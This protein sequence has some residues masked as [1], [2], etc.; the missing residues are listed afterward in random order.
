MT[1]REKRVLEQ[2]GCVCRCPQCQDILNDQAECQD[3][4]LVVYTCQC[5][6]VSR[7][8]FD[9][10]VPILIKGKGREISLSAPSEGPSGPHWA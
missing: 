6:H 2:C 8:L 4:D 5:G 1:K 9:A 10:P 3:D 7:W